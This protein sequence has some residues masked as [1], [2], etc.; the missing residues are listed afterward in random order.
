LLFSHLGLKSFSI[1]FGCQIDDCG[2]IE[3]GDL[4]KKYNVKS[5]AGN[6]ITEPKPFNLMFGT[7]IGPTG[8]FQ[9]WDYFPLP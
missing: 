5:P 3:L 6:D 1:F 4:L 7:Q 2:E 8:N 9:G